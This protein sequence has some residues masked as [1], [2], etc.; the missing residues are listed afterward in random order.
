MTD[1]ILLNFNQYTVPSVVYR[2]VSSWCVVDWDK[3]GDGKENIG[4]RY[5]SSGILKT[6]SN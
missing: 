5:Q 6:I 3:G 4:G 2:A 1:N